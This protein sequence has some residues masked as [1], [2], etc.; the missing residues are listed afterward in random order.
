MSNDIASLFKETWI[1]L[2]DNAEEMIALDEKIE[3]V[4]QW[5]DWVELKEDPSAY[6]NESDD[7]DD[8]LDNERFP[9]LLP[10]GT[11]SVEDRSKP[12]AKTSEI[13][14]EDDSVCNLPSKFPLN[15]TLLDKSML[16]PNGTTKSVIS[17]KSSTQW[18]DN[19]KITLADVILKSAEGNAAYLAQLH[20][21]T[22]LTTLLAL[23]ATEEHTMS[24][25]TPKTF[26]PAGHKNA[27]YRMLNRLGINLMERG[28]EGSRGRATMEAV[29]GDIVKFA[30]DNKEELSYTT[31]NNHKY[32]LLQL[33]VGK[34][35]EESYKWFKQY[36]VF[37]QALNT[38]LKGNDIT[39]KL[40]CML[41]YLLIRH[42][43]EARRALTNLG[44]LSKT[45]DVYEMSATMKKC[46]I[47]IGQWRELVKCFKKIMNFDSICVS[48]EAWRKLGF[49]VGK[50]KTNR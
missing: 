1:E 19:E 18:T 46:N 21:I 42:K 16:Q 47:V 40:E 34:P 30:E 27:K 44:I 38:I 15:N 41:D 43:E 14:M 50:I 12:A 25:P 35:I 20:T 39:S 3:A 11:T 31:F 4:K 8:S 17:N 7:D 24:I 48:E 10:H 23:P 32:L 36:Q 13:D 37:E 5:V 26:Y 28:E 22:N 45:L 9:Q 29:L 6:G 2:E 49:D 33:P